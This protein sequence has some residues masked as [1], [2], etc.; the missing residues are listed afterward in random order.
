MAATWSGFGKKG[1]VLSMGDTNMHITAGCG[2]GLQ[3]LPVLVEVQAPD[4]TLQTPL[5]PVREF[6]ETR[7]EDILCGVS[8][9]ELLL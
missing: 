3:G 6:R 5:Q 1:R 2:P 7:R 9:M 8:R 4:T